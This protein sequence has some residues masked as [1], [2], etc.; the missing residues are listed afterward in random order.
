[1]KYYIDCEFDGFDGELISMA[2]VS[3][4][5]RSFYFINKKYEHLGSAKEQ[6]VND[7]VIPILFNSPQTP[8]VDKLENIPF[9]IYSY[10][11]DDLKEHEIPHFIS[12]W[13]EDIKYLCKSVLTGPG[14]MVSINTFNC[15]VVRVNSYPNDIEGA[16]QHNAWWDAYCLKHRL[17]EGQ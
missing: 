16:Y 2:F 13:P 7:N 3:Q 1:M 6:W 15:S 8:I 4:S 11:L 5:D 9:H 17:S 10:L 12:D 14:Q